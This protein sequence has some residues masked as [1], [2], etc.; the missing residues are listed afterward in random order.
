[1]AG[2]FVGIQIGAISFVDEGIDQVLDILQQKGAVN[3]LVIGSL[4]WSR[5]TAGRSAQASVDHGATGEDK[6]IGGALWEPDPKYY[7]NTTL[8][9]FRSPLYQGFDTLGDVIPAAKKRGMKVFPYYC[10]TPE[11]AIRHNNVP[12]AAQVVEVDIF[13]R[14]TSWPC[15]NNPQYRAWVFSFIEDWC[16]HEIDGILWGIERQS[17][18]KQMLAGESANCFCKYCLAKGAQLNIDAE[19]AREGYKELHTYLTKLRA[20]FQPRDGHFVS[21]LRIL[22]KYPE[23]LQWEKLWLESHR[24]LHRELAGL[25]KFLDPAKRVG[26][27][28]WQVINTFS[29]YLR[30]QYDYEEFRQYADWLK[31][32]VYNVPAGIR[33]TRYV[34]SFQPGLFHRADEAAE[35]YLH[36]GQATILEDFS[37]QET[38]DLFYR[39]LHLDEAPDAELAETGLSPEYVRR[40]TR[41]TVEAVAGDVAVYPGIGIGVPGGPGSKEIEPDD[42][43]A[44]IR[45]AYEGG[46][47]GVLLSRNYSETMLHNLEAAGDVLR[48][49]GRV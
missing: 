37:R 15:N 36:E 49:L 2:G 31:P 24:E 1:M 5:G 14:K 30:A 35:E 27:G 34:R 46:A 19:R 48:E 12:G 9:D 47:T 29:P 11:A 21:F 10:E 6:L 25:V 8:K 44:A 45:A 20:G 41:R 13:G 40:E 17:G 38:L 28:I 43:K 16:H 4:S 26:F 22:L 32:I 18:L 23:V 33:F 42:V 3:S 7:G 39:L